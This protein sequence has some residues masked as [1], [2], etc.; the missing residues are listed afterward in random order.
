LRG[1]KTVWIPG[2]FSK[3]ISI[4]TTPNAR[5]FWL[6]Q[7]TMATLSLLD[8][9]SFFMPLISLDIKTKEVGIKAF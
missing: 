5:V 6:A 3:N 1:A 8:I 2:S 9:A 4:S 7:N